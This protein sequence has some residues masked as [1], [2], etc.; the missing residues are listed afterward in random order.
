MVSHLKK[1]VEQNYEKG[2]EVLF[3][4]GRIEVMG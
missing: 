3:R 1:R 4:N 2:S